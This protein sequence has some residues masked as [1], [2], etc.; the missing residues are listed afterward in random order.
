MQLFVHVVFIIFCVF[1]I[2]IKG[3]LFLYNKQQ[4]KKQQNKAIANKVVVFEQKVRNYYMEIIV[5]YKASVN[6]N[7]NMYITSFV[8]LPATI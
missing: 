4:K 1:L 2:A 8:F 3:I 7:V 5:L 6:S